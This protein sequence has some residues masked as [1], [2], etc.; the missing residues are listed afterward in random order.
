MIQRERKH[1][2]KGVFS[3]RA[4]KR[5]YPFNEQDTAA[6]GRAP[7]LDV[8]IAKVS[9][10]SSLPFEDAG[11]PQDP[12]DKKQDF[13]SLKTNKPGRLQAKYSLHMRSQVLVGT[14]WAPGGRHPRETLS[15][16]PTLRVQQR[17]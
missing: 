11:A 15:S 12:L 6:W 5:K 10:K 2:D 4:L 13:F 14:A 1:P 3:S 9:K 7:K 8:P 17:L 16:L